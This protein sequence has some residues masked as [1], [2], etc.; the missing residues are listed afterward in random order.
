MKR[1]ITREEFYLEGGREPAWPIV[2]VIL[3]LLATMGIMVL[4][5]P[6]P[7]PTPAETGRPAL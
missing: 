2:V 7:P 3:G 4:S 6:E 1:H 5:M